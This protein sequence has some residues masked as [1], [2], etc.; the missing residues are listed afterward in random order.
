MDIGSV[1]QLRSGGVTMTVSAMDLAGSSMV[2]C[3]W[4]TVDGEY[5]WAEIPLAVLKEVD[6]NSFVQA[7]E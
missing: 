1:V 7:N 5:R 4:L 3:H 6:V 2:T